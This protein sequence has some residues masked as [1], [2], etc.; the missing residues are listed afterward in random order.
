VKPPTSLQLGGPGDDDV[1]D[2]EVTGDLVIAAGYRNGILGQ[3]NVEPVGNAAGFVDGYELDGR[4][5]WHR[6]F[7]TSGADTVEAMVLTDTELAIA[8]RTSGVFPGAMNAGGM[9]AFVARMRL[10][11]TDV[12]E[13]L[14]FGDD[15]PQHPV[16]IARDSTG[17]LLVAGYDDTHVVGGAVIA[18]ED[19]L[20][21]RVRTDAA[22]LAL[23][24]FRRPGTAGDD[25]YEG[26]VAPGPAGEVIVS[27]RATAGADKGTFVRRL[28]A[29]GAV[30]WQHMFSTTGVDAIT[31][32][33]FGPDGYVYATGTTFAAIAATSY[34]EQDVFVVALDPAT[35]EIKRKMQGGSDKSDYPRDVVVAADG[36]VYVT[37][38]TAGT[39]PGATASGDYDAM[40]LRFG[41]D[42]EWTGAWQRG[43]A[44]D[45]VGRSI[46]ITPTG[47]VIGGYANGA[48][49]PGAGH[50]GRRDGFVFHVART[51]LD[52][53]GP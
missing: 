50:Q 39:L 19:P 8:G 17:A 37:G 21:T 14:M 13:V 42:D 32:L 28:D 4:L 30:V 1:L 22:T 47:V 53:L 41:P 38:E 33:A 11:A 49:V 10:D 18:A 16:R 12:P 48:F 5:R 34:G 9:D 43:T 7:D 26:L 25:V 44:G 35:G 2:V 23:D 27:G 40:A 29:T 3:E 24:F 52:L 46:A 6:S 36:T 20:V 31:A 15:R 51:E 45:D